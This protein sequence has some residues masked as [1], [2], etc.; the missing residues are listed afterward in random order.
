MR[1]PDEIKEALAKIGFEAEDIA[2]R[3]DPA[4]TE[5]RRGRELFAINFMIEGEALSIHDV[6]SK[7]KKNET[8]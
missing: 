5:F 3:N 2:P 4:F 8:L 1:A 7:F 6:L